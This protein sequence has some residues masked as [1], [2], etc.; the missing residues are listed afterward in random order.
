VLRC[1]KWCLLAS[2]GAYGRNN[3]SFEDLEKISDE[4]LSS[5]YHTLYLWTTAYVSLLSF[6]FFVFLAH[7]CN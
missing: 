1:G 4:I 7:F 6:R 2:F 3:W 5:F